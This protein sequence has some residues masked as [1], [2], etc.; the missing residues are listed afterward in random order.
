M[1]IAVAGLTLKKIDTFNILKNDRIKS[2]FFS[3][4]TILFIYNYNIFGSFK[5]FGYSGLKE[6]IAGICL[7]ISFYL[8]PFDKIKNIIIIS[9]IKIITRYTGGIY[10]LQTIIYYII[11]K[12]KYLNQNSF[13]MCFMIYIFGYLICIIFTKLFRNNRLKYLFL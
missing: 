5:S 12:F 4:I 7:F 10:Y 3:T 9:Y 6:H 2:I 1:P 8:I 13:Y 11:K